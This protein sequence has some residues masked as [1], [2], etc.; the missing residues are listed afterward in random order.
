MNGDLAAA[1]A[2]LHNDHSIRQPADA[3]AKLVADLERLQSRGELTKT[4][5][6]ALA[7]NMPV[8][9]FKQNQLDSASQYARLLWESVSTAS[10]R[11]EVTSSIST[12]HFHA[13]VQ[14]GVLQTGSGSTAQ[15]T[16]NQQTLAV[17]ESFLKALA[18]AKAAA[19]SEV[20]DQT[21]RDQGLAVIEAIEVEAR[22][23]EPNT[24]KIMRL[25][26]SV[27]NWGGERFTKAIDTA[28]EVG[29]RAGL[30]L[31]PT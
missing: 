8:Q 28:I 3:Q 12:T 17:G 23:P 18:D 22:K 13:P 10:P 16:G 7:A 15:W 9:F 2:R 27:A 29:V 24:A 21:Q 6:S 4:A 19:R 26:K 20:I 25:L 31:P 14:A 1:V 11:D 5:V 30:G